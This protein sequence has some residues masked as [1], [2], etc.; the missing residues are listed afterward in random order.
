MLD[1]WLRESTILLPIFIAYNERECLSSCMHA[2]MDGGEHVSVDW[3]GEVFDHAW[4][5][6]AIYS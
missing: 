5:H 1:E 2:C 6:I 3:H 4:H